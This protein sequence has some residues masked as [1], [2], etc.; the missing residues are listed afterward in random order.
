MQYRAIDTR[1][2]LVCRLFYQEGVGFLY[3]N[4][5]IRIPCVL[6]RNP[7]IYAGDLKLARSIVLRPLIERTRLISDVDK[8][9]ANL[10]VSF[11]GLIKVTIDVAWPRYHYAVGR[12]EKAARRH[13]RQRT[14]LRLYNA[15]K[16]ASCTTSVRFTGVAH[17]EAI[18]KSNLRVIIQ[19]STIVHEFG[20]HGL[21]LLVIPPG[22]PRLFN[23]QH[24]AWDEPYAQWLVNVAAGL[25]CIGGRSPASLARRSN[26]RG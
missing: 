8:L 20:P 6:T 24:R 4:N 25:V 13:G 12:K 1:I 23:M 17:V 10:A 5:T 15:F 2:L 21:W 16:Q 9:V 22:H 19:H 26:Y 14:L 7:Y 11:P 3:E 18:T